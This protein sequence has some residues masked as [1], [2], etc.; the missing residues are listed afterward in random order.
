MCSK[1]FIPV[2]E[3]WC[4]VL[5]EFLMV[6]IIL[7]GP[8]INTEG[9]QMRC[10]PRKIITAVIL[11]G[12]MDMEHHKDTCGEKVASQDD[13]I[14]GGP[15]AHC[16]QLP[17]SQALC[18]QNKGSW[19]VVVDCMESDVQPVVQQVPDE[20]LE[21]K[22]KKVSRHT[23]MSSTRVGTWSG[24]VTGGLHV[25]WATLAGSTR[26]IWL[27]RLMP[28]QCNS[29][30]GVGRRLGWILNSG[31]MAICPLWCHTPGWGGRTESMKTHSKQWGKKETS[32]SSCDWAWHYSREAE[33]RSHFPGR[34]PGL[35]MYLLLDQ[36]SF[37]KIK[38]V[39]GV[40]SLVLNV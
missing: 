10:G 17:P 37:C 19:V 7:A 38:N 32:K 35:K 14:Q 27:C 21:V 3:V 31:P 6:H 13:R 16:D 23:V 33:E 9:Y 30:E 22:E 29:M 4:N 8:S 18:S 5:V 39:N 26:S 34:F 24:S 12:H 15:K 28:A 11:H 40:H 20:V 25:H 2:A 1:Y 36:S